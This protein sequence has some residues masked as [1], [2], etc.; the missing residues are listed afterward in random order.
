MSRPSTGPCK[1]TS[2]KTRSKR[3][4]PNKAVASPPVLA[5]V[6]SKPSSWRKAAINARIE[7]SS[8]T[9]KTW[10]VA[11]CR[12]IDPRR[13]GRDH[14]VCSTSTLRSWYIRSKQSFFEEKDQKP[15]FPRSHQGEGYQCKQTCRQNQASPWRNR[16]NKSFLLLSFKKEGLFFF[17]N[18]SLNAD[19]RNPRPRTHAA[20]ATHEKVARLLH[21][22]IVERCIR[23]TKV[24]SAGQGKTRESQSQPAT[25]LPD[26]SQLDSPP[27]AAAVGCAAGLVTFSTGPLA[28]TV[29]AKTSVIASDG[30]VPVS[31]QLC[32]RSR[33][34]NTKS[35]R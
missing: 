16:R 15:L 3:R 13:L 5:S 26:A 33:H 21:P 8:S 28:F 18:V 20:R 1:S 35:S 12:F 31:T 19:G 24:L 9:S 10:I 23:R 25:S 7:P 34:N 4:R 2:L 30:A 11:A 6:T 27:G 14:S 29:R 17:A 22:G 32:E